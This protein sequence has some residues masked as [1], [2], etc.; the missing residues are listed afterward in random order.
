M[1]KITFIP[2][3]YVEKNGA[4]AVEFYKLAFDAIELRRWTNDDG[5]V[6]VSE[7]E[8]GGAIFHIHEEKPSEGQFSPQTSGGITAVMGLMVSDPDAMMAKALA[9]GAKERRPMQDYDYGYRQGEVIDPFG[10]WWMFEKVI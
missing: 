7:L 3:L 10:H 9:A 4:Q 1:S 2:Q 8:I 5:T 6:H